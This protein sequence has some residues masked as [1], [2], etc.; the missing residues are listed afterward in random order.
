MLR[1]RRPTAPVRPLSRLSATA[2]PQEAGER[3]KESALLPRFFNGGAVTRSVTEGA[4]LL[5]C[6]LLLG[7]RCRAGGCNPPPSPPARHGG[8]HPPYGS[9]KFI[10]AR[11]RD[12]HLIEPARPPQRVDGQYTDCLSPV[13]FPGA[14]RRGRIAADAVVNHDFPENPCRCFHWLILNRPRGY[15]TPLE[16]GL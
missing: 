2:P 14:S 8:L 9:S 4:F 16:A 13:E 12:H 7:E 5:F 15:P 6:P 11:S 1:P 3:K 10:R